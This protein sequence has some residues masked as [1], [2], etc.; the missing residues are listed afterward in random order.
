MRGIRSRAVTISLTTGAPN[1]I[2]AMPYRGLDFRGLSSRRAG[3]TWRSLHETTQSA[4]QT[5]HIPYKPEILTLTGVNATAFGFGLND[6]AFTFNLF[7]AV[8]LCICVCAGDAEEG[9]AIAGPDL[10]AVGPCPV[11]EAGGATPG[12]FPG[13]LNGGIG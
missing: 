8:G 6:E 9:I 11:A 7:A 13:P 2:E 3:S 4:H 5:L 1:T 10:L 12:F